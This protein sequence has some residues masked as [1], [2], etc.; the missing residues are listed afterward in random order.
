MILLA[1]HQDSFTRNLEHLLAGFDRVVVRD[2]RELTPELIEQCHLLVLSPGPGKPSD[3][4]ETL[5]LF[6]SCV[7]CKPVL[8][9]CLG[10]QLMLEAEG[11]TIH[12]Q[13]L[14]LHGIETEL[15]TLPGSITY[16]GLPAGIR[17]G[18][19]HSLQVDPSSLSCLPET[20][21]ITGRDPIR[22]VP[23][24]FEDLPRKLFGLQYHPESFLTCEGNRLIRNIRNA[25]LDAEG[26]DLGTS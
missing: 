8:G 19:Y 24:S 25:C 12:R 13:S 23:L 5:D 2:R 4:P 17:V 22:D 21:R 10:F 14:V 7:G 11:A 1:D 15:E 9:I 26:G 16:Q 3:Y 6:R 18:R 20:L